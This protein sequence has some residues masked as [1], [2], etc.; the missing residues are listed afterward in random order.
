L[1]AKKRKKKK[2][3]SKTKL[4]WKFD[5]SSAAQKLGEGPGDKFSANKEC[6]M[7][8]ARGLLAR[9]LLGKDWPSRIRY[10]CGEEV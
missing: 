5:G 2:E 9:S 1:I 4:R 7:P 8:L 10:R 3:I 6:R